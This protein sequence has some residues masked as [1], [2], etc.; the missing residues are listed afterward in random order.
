MVGRVAQDRQ[1]T[2]APQLLQGILHDRA[3]VSVDLIDVGV[4]ASMTA[5]ERN[6]SSVFSGWHE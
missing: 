1:S 4:V 6:A 5:P 3:H 2:F